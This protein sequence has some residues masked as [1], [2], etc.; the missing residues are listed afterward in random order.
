MEV[1][2]VWAI[3][4]AGR[5]DDPL[6]IH[7]LERVLP[8]AGDHLLVLVGAVR[9]AHYGKRGAGGTWVPNALALVD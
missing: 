9:F 3:S 2:S 8:D 7:F 6:P 5:E 4:S 1:V